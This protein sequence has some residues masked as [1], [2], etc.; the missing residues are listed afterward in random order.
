MDDLLILTHTRWQL[1]HALARM[2]RG[3]AAAG[4]QQHP[5]KTL[6]GRPERGFDWMGYQFDA[7][8]LVAVATGALDNLQEKLRRPPAALLGATDAAAGG[9]VPKPQA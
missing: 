8:G 7:S 6:I 1:R 2:N 3:L 9:G 4:L 5:G